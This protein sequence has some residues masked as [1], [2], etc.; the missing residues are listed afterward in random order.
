MLRNLRENPTLR[1][2]T[3]S[4][5]QRRGPGSRVTRVVIGR[6]CSQY[7]VQ[8]RWEPDALELVKHQPAR[9]LRIPPRHF[10]HAVH[11]ARAFDHYFGAV[12][13]ERSG[14]TLVV[15]YS[16]PRI[17][18]YPALGVDLVIPSFTESI[19]MEAWYFPHAR[20]QPGDLV[21]D[22]GAN[23]GICTIHLAREVGSAGHVVAIEPDPINFAALETNVARAGLENV[24]LVRKAVAETTGEAT[25]YA[26]GTSG[27]ALASDREASISRHAEGEVVTVS[28][29]TLTNLV[30]EFGEPSFI[31]LDIEGSEIPVVDQA[32]TWL[33]AHLP[34]LVIDTDH[35]VGSETTER[36]VAE[37][38]EPIGYATTFAAATLDR[39]AM[40]YANRES[41]GPASAGA[42]V[43]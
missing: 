40:L 13:P 1:R 29:T 18:H 36:R 37:I 5:L 4:V 43:A 22:C 2:C 34:H 8:C 9:V 14:G 24:T 11:L 23:I 33:A 10:V 19:E 20:P 15:D 28:T 16:R 31:K 6:L 38:L 35:V 42:P 17:H 21:F 41:G 12:A 39:P 7:D 3:I 30:A 26:D 25:F 27:S 32:Q